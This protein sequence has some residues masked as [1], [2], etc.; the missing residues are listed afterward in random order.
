VLP[1]FDVTSLMTM[2]T[3]KC[4]W[5]LVYVVVTSLAAAEAGVGQVMILED[6][7]LTTLPAGKP[8][9]PGECCCVSVT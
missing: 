1:Q 6:E 3:V 4:I 9:I 8:I 7:P 5:R 2:E